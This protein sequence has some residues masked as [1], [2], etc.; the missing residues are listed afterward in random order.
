MLYPVTY[1]RL[2]ARELRLDAEG[3]RRLL[4]GTSLSPED[5]VSLDQLISEPELVVI[6]RN[7]LVLAA[8]PGFG[9][10]VGSRLSVAAHGPL[11][12]L[13]SSSENLGEAWAALERFHGL[14]VPMV[15][16]VREFDASHMTIRL[17]LQRPLDDVGMFLLEIMAVTV[18]RGV[19]LV[20]G[21]RLREA[22]LR[23]E[24][25]EPPHVELFTRH[26]HSPCHFAAGETVWRIPRRLLEQPN[27]FRDRQQ[28]QA[29]LQHCEQL[30]QALRNE[31][32]PAWG[33]RIT[34]LLQENPGQLWTL[35]DIAS[36]YHLSPRTLIRHLKREGTSYQALLDAELSRQALECFASAGH[37]VE[38][39]AL[40][41]GYKDATAFR[42][43]FRRWF[44]MP[45]REYL[46]AR[47]AGQVSSAPS[48]E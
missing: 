6:L 29:A 17:L 34:G 20:I 40:S 15:Q 9:L 35:A 10:E 4:Q 28:Y 36:H 24:F 3:Q 1:C 33:Q 32:S 21:R 16:I 39:V 12:Q 44:G 7:A 46:A 43:A 27:P 5:L 13:L 8:R 30:E 37:T 48:A 31:Q 2:A 25:A 22:E 47:F 19:E 42:R 26:I 38:S 41:L 18:Q 14:R 23:L 45:P 11:G